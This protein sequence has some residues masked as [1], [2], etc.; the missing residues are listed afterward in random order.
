MVVRSIGS[1]NRMV[2][3]QIPA[4]ATHKLCDLDE[5]NSL[6]LCLL[7]GKLKLMKTEPSQQVSYVASM[8]QYT[9]ST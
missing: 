6:S 8:N 3:F 2:G 9:L 7:I 5:L 1:G 4:A